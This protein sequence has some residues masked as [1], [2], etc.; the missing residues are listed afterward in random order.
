MKASMDRNRSTE[1]PALARA[2][3]RLA[4][5]PASDAAKDVVLAE[6]RLATFLIAVTAEEAR[7]G[8][9]DT[10]G[11][12]AAPQASEL[13]ILTAEQDDLQYLPL[14]TDWQEIAGFTDLEVQ[15]L[16]MAA[17]DVWAFALEDGYDGVVINPNGNALPLGKPL[18]EF[19]SR[20]DST[21]N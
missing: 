3:E 19:L 21:A 2:L 5:D 13:Q 18:L 6:L 16:I 10:E 11:D 12:G 7:E 20:D 15:G 4:N 8:G 1:N 9:E 17:R 14:F